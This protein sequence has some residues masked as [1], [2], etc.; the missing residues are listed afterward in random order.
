MRTPRLLDSYALLAYL[1]GEAGAEKVRSAMK[2]GRDRGQSLL[3]SEI[4]IGEVYYILSRKRGMD[5]ADYFVET[6][7]PG[8]PISVLPV[9]SPL[10]MEA[11]RLKAKYP[12]SYADCFAVAT[13]MRAKA[14]VMTGDPEFKAASD[15]ITVEWLIDGLSSL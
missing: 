14:A 13:A 9:D 8:L 1:N 4:N 2:E 12:L 15:L 10:V 5:K 3:M 11:A 7:L 6:V